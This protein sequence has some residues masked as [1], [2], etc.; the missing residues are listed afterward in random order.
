[1][2]FSKF[3][4]I[5][6]A[7]L[8]S[9]TSIFAQQNILPDPGF[10]ALD[11]P[12]ADGWWVYSKRGE[13]HAIV[14]QKIAHSGKQS[15]RLSS[16]PDARF[17]FL[18]P[19]LQVANE[20][21]I[22]FSGWIRCD[23]EQ[24]TNNAGISIF[25]RDRDGRIVDRARVFPTHIKPGKWQ[26]LKSTAKAPPRSAVADFDV[27]CSNLVGSV[28]ADDVSAVV[29]SPQSMFL[30]NE[31]KPWP[32]QHEV[33]VRII[34]RQAGAFRGTLH[35]STDERTSD[36]PVVLPRLSTKKINVPITLSTPGAHHYC[37]A[38]LDSAG[39]RQRSIEGKFHI[40]QPLTVFP[41]CPSYL[42]IAPGASD[43][44]V[45]ARVIVNPSQRSRLRLAATLRDS[46]GK[47]IAQSTGDASHGEFVGTK[48]RVPT[49]TEATYTISVRLLA[50]DGA[51]IANGETDVHVHPAADSVVTTDRNGFFRVAGQPEFPI[52][53]YSC[54]HYDEMSEGGFSATHSY[55]I[56]LGDGA[57]PIN[58][59]DGDVK[60]LLDQNAKYHM[61]MMVELPRHA[62]EKAQ[63]AQVRRRIETFRNH[64]GLLCWGSEERVAR[65]E[66]SLKNIVTLYKLVH[67]LDPNHP[68]VLGDTKDII[69][70]LMV[71]RRNFFPDQAMDA[72][73]WWWYPI[74]LDG[75][76][77]EP[78]DGQEKVAKMLEPPQWLTTTTSK[79]P[80]WIAI[81]S[82]QHPKKD[83]RF[84]TPAEYRCMAYLSII[85]HVRGLWFYTGS[86]QRDFDGNPAGILNKPEEGHWTY[87]K[88]LVHELRELSPVIMSPS[89]SGVSLSPTN[90]AIE[91]SA[92][93]FDHKRY[94][95]AANKSSQ[96]Q[97]AHFTS[98]I[99]AGKQARVLYEEH[100]VTIDGNSLTDT[101][102]PFG[103]HV[104][105]VE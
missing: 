10:E 61:R 29:T 19:K 26:L 59:T 38:L 42:N 28:W 58:V 67:E 54:S 50:R 92:H 40:S 69:Q 7:L 5:V 46:S 52:G 17:V 104:Y 100:A 70:H 87:V 68:L 31:P 14:D 102:E 45:D 11:G 21:E 9:A 32:G 27:F 105:H 84:P 93:E 74:P 71:D 34:N 83:A 15:V 18:S 88:Q 77:G 44:R 41:A 13:A 43:V 60:R 94:L 56:T 62:I 99:F 89:V 96:P 91:F 76:D 35:V 51:E 75:D 65:G 48:L 1:M 33:T 81:Q 57:D 80:L 86:G 73:I 85:N 98:A 20:D 30:D 78:L 4:S 66:T 55:S 3:R 22:V 49:A 72:G 12:P 16:T 101:F 36:L 6:A 24:D 8:W 39:N 79:K 37:I 82:Y 25:F 97:T 90:T 23:R 103:V 53:L 64:P 2:S 95:F 63:W 47:E